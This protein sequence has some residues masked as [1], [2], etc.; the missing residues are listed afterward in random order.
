VASLQ[1]L[2]QQGPTLVTSHPLDVSIQGDGFLTVKQGTQTLLT[3]AGNLSFDG[4]GN[5]VDQN[6][7]LVRGWN[8]V[9][10]WTRMDINSAAN[11]GLLQVTDASFQLHSD[12]MTQVTSIQV[13]RDLVL[14]PKATT[15]IEFKGNLDAFQQANVIDLFPPT[16]PA[17]PVAVPLA[18][19]GGPIDVSRMTT[20]PLPSGGFAL[21]QTGNLATFVPGLYNPPAPLENG[22]INLAFAQVYAGSYVWDQQPPVPPAHVISKGVFDSLGNPREI[23][24]HF[25]QVND[26]GTAVPPI[27]T[28][29]MSQVCYTWYAFDTTGNKTVT[30]ANLVGGT[31]IGEGEI[32][33]P[34][35]PFFPVAFYDR[36]LP[37]TAYFG[38]Y[39]WFNTDGSLASMGGVGGFPGPP[40]LN[41]N[42]QVVPR[43]YL[44]PINLNPP[45]SPIPV[46]GAE[47]LSVDLDFGLAGLLGGSGFVPTGLRNGLYSDA[48]GNYELI[49]GVNTYVPSHTAYAATQNGYT[50]GSLL[51]L[52]FEG[53]GTLVGSFSNGEELGIA[54]LALTQVE[55]PEGLSKVGNGYFTPSAN[56]GSLRLGTAGIG[57]LG[58]V[59][60]SALEGSNVDLTLELS[61]MIVAQRGFD[62]NARMVSTVNSTMDTMNRLGL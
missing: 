55:N 30:T 37:N 52:R 51:D 53:D 25:Y 58:R 1:N 21:A 62:V 49:N 16:G 61:N 10:E 47:I 57:G 14:P 41:F 11:G 48:G 7:A 26:L 6:G 46:L 56:A 50:D 36:G 43:V 4:E 22:F 29:P 42:F 15:K 17:L 23:T 24:V 59:Q 39:I 27:N 33:T 40:G 19:V 18:F 8:A 35:N 20:V 45:V 60:G 32:P 9:P 3:R 5:L 44:P 34:G 12:N 38:D 2:F 54:R 31:G 28:P 13:K